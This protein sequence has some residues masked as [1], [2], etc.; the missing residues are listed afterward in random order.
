[1]TQ[2]HDSGKLWD[3]SGKSFKSK[4]RFQANEY[5]DDIMLSKVLTYGRWR[6]FLISTAAE[7]REA[8]CPYELISGQL[9][10]NRGDRAINR[11]LRSASA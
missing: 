2:T 5:A 1:M 7:Y 9:S 4:R 10:T 6:G 3:E 8:K 11:V